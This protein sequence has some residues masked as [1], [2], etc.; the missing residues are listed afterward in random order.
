MNDVGEKFPGVDFAGVQFDNM[1]VFLPF[2]TVLI[3]CE[4][5]ICIPK[6]LIYTTRL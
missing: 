1:Q 3:F 5:C 6:C 2:V 4:S